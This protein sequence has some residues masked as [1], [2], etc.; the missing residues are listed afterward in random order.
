M[1][2][3]NISKKS[4]IYRVLT[5]LSRGKSFN[6]FQAEIEL[7]DHSLYG[8]VHNIQKRYGITVSRKDE[9]V[10][11]YMGSKT[12]CC[13]YWLTEDQQKKAKLLLTDN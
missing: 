5:A 3:S 7:H 11:G 6:R 10:P 2:R 1:S 12:H 13:R 8:T 9:I 4:K